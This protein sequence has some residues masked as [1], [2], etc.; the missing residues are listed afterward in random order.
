MTK[1]FSFEGCKA[2]DVIVNKEGEKAVILETFQNTFVC[3]VFGAFNVYGIICTYEEASIYGWTFEEVEERWKPENGEDYYFINTRIF[4][5]KSVYNGT[6]NRNIIMV[7][8]NC[9]QTLEEAEAKC[10][11]IR[12]ILKG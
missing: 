9:F 6:Y 5:T 2:G 7:E 10:I 4:P 12:K 8:E 11:E 1:T 3:S